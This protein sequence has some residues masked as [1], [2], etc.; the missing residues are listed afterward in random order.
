MNR[1]II[2]LISFVLFACK[3][4]SEKSSVMGSTPLNKFVFTQDIDHFWQA[5]DSINQVSDYATKLELIN[6]MYIDKGTEG[7]EEFMKLRD[8]SDTL[9][10]KLIEDLP[11]FWESIRPNTLTVKSR[12]KEINQSIEILRTLYPELKP[13]KIYFTI[14]GMRSGGT[15]KGN[16]S[17]IGCEIATADNEINTSE[18]KAH[19]HDWLVPFFQSQNSSKLVKTNV[20]EFIHTQQKNMGINLISQALHEG[21]C[22]FIT[23]LVTKSQ[24][25]SHYMK[26]GEVN[27]SE[28]K[29][30]FFKEAFLTDYTNWF[31][32]ADSRYGLQDLGYFM[33]YSICK[34]FYEKAENKKSAI[35]QIIELDHSDLEA[36][37]R[38]TNSS[39]YFNQ[40]LE[41]EME[42]VTADVFSYE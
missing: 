6:S 20:H 32:N 31:Y 40:P 33:G 23:E 19:G 18:F 11:L 8:Y 16:L 3:G 17:L 38:F 15:V 2:I 35:K 14:G 39:E 37:V 21:S 13:A 30:D 4:D 5:F 34:A 22:D 24:L 41:G 27:E 9:Y 12:E 7:L 42:R 29:K 28:L 25:K 1:I 26:F 36:V 10:V